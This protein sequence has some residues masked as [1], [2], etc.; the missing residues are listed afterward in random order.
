MRKPFSDLL[1]NSVE[2]TT[3]FHLQAEVIPKLLVRQLNQVKKN[4]LFYRKKMGNWKIPDKND[5]IDFHDALPFT[6]KKELLED[7]ELFPPYGCNLTVPQE[8]IQRINRTSGTTGVPLLLALTRKDITNTYECGA[9]CFYASGLRRHHTVIH[10][11]NYCMW[12][13]GYT[14]HG[15][16]EY[17][18]AAV[19]PFGVGNSKMLIETILQI[20]PRVLHATPSYLAKLEDVVN[21]EFHLAPRELGLKLGLF[22]GEAGLQDPNFRQRIEKIWGFKAMNANYGSADVLSMFGAE[23][24][25]RS[26]LHFM[27]QGII[28]PTLIDRQTLKKI[29]IEAGAIGELVLT[30]LLKEAQPVI[31]YR[32][33]DMIEILSTDLCQCGRGSLRFKVLGRNDDMLVIKG[34]NV[35]PTS[36][37]KV[38]NQNLDFLT[39]QFRILVNTTDPIDRI[40]IRAEIHPGACPEVDLVSRLERMFV[41]HLSI[42]PEIELVPEGALPRAENK[43]KSLQRIL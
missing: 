6:D 22:G 43:T 25:L 42:R 17:L 19:I 15:S 38:I 31:R 12:A 27:G 1:W 3:D 29:P 39:G 37:Q 14:D 40:I 20:R 34:I 8:M 26:G 16:L 35:F 23:C 33:H 2:Q 4:S 41:A 28:Y 21:Q 30:N 5:I 9:R 24:H 32:T 13:G 11:L 36:I 7:Q 10:C 18:G